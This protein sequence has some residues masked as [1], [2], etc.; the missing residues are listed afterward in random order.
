[1]YLNINRGSLINVL[2]SL[3]FILSMNQGEREEFL[4]EPL[5]LKADHNVEN[6]TQSNTIPADCEPVYN[7][8]YTNE[9]VIVGGIPLWR[10][11]TVSCETGGE[12]TC[13]LSQRCQDQ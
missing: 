9:P 2:I 5:V 4:S 3:F 11:I 12:F 8:T 10:V 13:P 1:M 7:V 6:Q